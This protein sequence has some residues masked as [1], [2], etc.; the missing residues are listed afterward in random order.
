VDNL[1]SLSLPHP[2][3]A[4]HY[5]PITTPASLPLIVL[6]YDP[7][8]NIGSRPGLENLDFF[9]RHMCGFNMLEQ[10][11]PPTEQD[12]HDADVEFIAQPAIVR[13]MGRC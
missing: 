4:T 9:E 12:R 6:L 3:P 2:L 8:P 13:T 10:A 5:T 11:Q 7:E 1:A